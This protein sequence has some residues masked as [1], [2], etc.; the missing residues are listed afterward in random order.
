MRVPN[1]LNPDQARHFVGP[2]LGQNCMQRLSA[3]NTSRQSSLFIYFSNKTADVGTKTKH[4]HLMK[5]FQNGHHNKLYIIIEK[6]A[7]S[8]PHFCGVDKSLLSNRTA[9]PINEIKAQPKNLILLWNIASISKIYSY[10]KFFHY[11]YLLE[12]KQPKHIT[13]VDNFSHI[14]FD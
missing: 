5:I 11:Q 2:D 13:I 14:W 12:D 7:E 10:M 6:L 3:E 4:P 1:S 9:V 8:F